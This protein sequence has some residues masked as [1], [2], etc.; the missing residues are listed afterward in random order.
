MN[1]PDRN[2]GLTEIYVYVLRDADTDSQSCV[3]EQV[4]PTPEPK[5]GRSGLLRRHREQPRLRGTVAP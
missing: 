5:F 4:P 1:Y 3:T 2:S